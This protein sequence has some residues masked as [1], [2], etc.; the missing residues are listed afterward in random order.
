MSRSCGSG[1]PRAAAAPDGILQRRGR[2]G[3]STSPLADRVARTPSGRSTTARLMVS[4]VRP[5]TDHTARLTQVLPAEA[6]HVLPTEVDR[7]ASRPAACGCRQLCHAPE[8]RLRGRPR[9]I[10]VPAWPSMIARRA[11]RLAYLMLVRVLGWLALLARS[12]IAKD[13]E[14]LTLRHEIAVLRRTNPPP[15]ISGSTAPC[16]AR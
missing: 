7:S 9:S 15:N 4:R 10:T 14:T 2:C 3:G 1:D 12:D 13:V 16:S 6:T 8:Q 11:L 5:P